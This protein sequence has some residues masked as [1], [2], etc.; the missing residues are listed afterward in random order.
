MFI[1]ISEKT[2]HLLLH[3]FLFGIDSVYL[4]FATYGNFKT[5]FI[6]KF[7]LIGY[8]TEK[9]KAL[10]HK[11]CRNASDLSV[12]VT[13]AVIF[14]L[15]VISF[16]VLMEE[17]RDAPDTCECNYNVDN[18]RKKSFGTSCNPCNEVEG[19]KTDKTPV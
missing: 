1:S 13:L 11:T 2:L 6:K 5:N 16:V 14:A 18:S 17:K 15:N 7:L 8:V 3:L 10:R 19:E 12:T 9:E 4:I